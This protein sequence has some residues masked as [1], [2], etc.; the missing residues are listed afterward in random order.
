MNEITRYAAI[1][2]AAL[3]EEDYLRTL[4]GAAAAVGAIDPHDM[5]RIADG[6]L[7]LLAAEAEAFTQGT[8]TSLPTEQVDQLHASICYTVSLALMPMNPDDAVERLK[9]EPIKGIFHAGRGILDRKIHAV[10]RF[11]P[12]LRSTLIPVDHAPYQFA[13]TRADRAFFKTY[14]SRFAAHALDWTP[15]YLP[16]LPLTRA[17]G[18]LYLQ[19]YLQSLHTENLICRALPPAVFT[20]LA[21]AQPVP[22]EDA[23]IGDI[24]VLSP[25]ADIADYNLCALLLDSLAGCADTDTIIARLN[26]RGRPAVYARRWLNSRTSSASAQGTAS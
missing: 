7:Y 24:G 2:P 22:F 19:D 12:I 23:E 10:A 11:M 8:S 3:R 1:D 17:G 5:A 18:I 13:V 25:G 26:L 20:R 16:C 15:A 6:F 21:A 9:T 4:L 14:D